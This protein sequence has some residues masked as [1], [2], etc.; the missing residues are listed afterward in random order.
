LHT[1][2]FLGP[3]NGGLEIQL[4]DKEILLITPESPLGQQLLGK[5]VG[6]R[7][8]LQLRGSGQEYRVISVI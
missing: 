6:D 1:L 2:Y 5:K 7:I 4:K 8:Q 3:K